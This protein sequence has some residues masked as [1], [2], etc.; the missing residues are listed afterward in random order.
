MY[1]FVLLILGGIELKLTDKLNNLDRYP[2]HM[3]GHKRNPKFGIIGSDIDVTEIEGL[4][5]LH[6]PKDILLEVEQEL[7]SIYKSSKSFLLVN[8]STVGI[9]SA[10]F[11]V[12]DEGDKIIVARNCHK[13][14]YNAC[15]LR[16]L[17]IVYIEPEF[18]R[19][20]GYY[21]RVLQSTVDEAVRSNPDA[22]AVVITSPTYEGTVSNIKCEPVLIIDGAHGAHLGL[23]NFPSYPQ[24]DI[25]VSSLHKTLPALT[26]TAVANVY[27]SDYIAGVKMYLD[28]FQSSS[29]SYV[30]MNSAAVC[31]EYIKNNK[32]E[33]YQYYDRLCH[34]REMNLFHLRLMYSDDYSKLVISTANTDITGVELADI[35]RNKY[36]IEIEMAAERY[37]IAMTSIGDSEEIFTAFRDALEDIDSAL[38][39][40]EQP[41]LKKPPLPCGEQCIIIS[42]ESCETPLNE[43]MGRISNE[44]VYAY[45]P[46][47]PIIS[48]NEKI[49]KQAV[50]YIISAEK[51]GVNIISD[52]ALMPNKLLT[53]AE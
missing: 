52:S 15:M 16:H 7:E 47:I 4:D 24:G 10:V 33:F 30:L 21:T 45:P 37:I 5:N 8:G 41:L 36:S 42:K 28:V 49:S 29:P 11:S 20:N 40:R 1:C 26:Q 31:C 14:V 53:K 2:L 48:P 12:C 19:A 43:S 39:L 44:F 46:D 9:L 50:D 38:I 17:R 13:S 3:P 22:K 35:L 18:D 23:G 32:R 6:N 51:A 25:V 34:L 27:N